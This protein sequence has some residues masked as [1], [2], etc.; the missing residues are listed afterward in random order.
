MARQR[1][2]TGRPRGGARRLTQWIGPALQGYVAVADGGATLIGSVPLDEASTIVRVRGHLSVLAAAVTADDTIVG[3]FGVAIVS[4]EAFTAGVGSMP[5]PFTDADWGGWMVWQAFSYRFEFFDGTGAN[6][7]DWDMVI[8]SKAMRK[9][10][11]NERLVL[12]AESQDG[13]FQIS[14][15]VRIL[16]KLS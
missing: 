12:I 9:G 5:E 13:G 10:G 15:P 6:F 11:P 2:F 7:P 14:T 1:G 8:D 16:V 3:A 4:S